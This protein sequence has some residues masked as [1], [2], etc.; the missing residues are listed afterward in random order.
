VTPFRDLLFNEAID[1]EYPPVDL[2]VLGGRKT[3]SELLATLDPILYSARRDEWLTSQLDAA[4][5]GDVLPPPHVGK[6]RERFDHLAR[7]VA[8]QRVVPFVGA[9]VSA[10][11]GF[12]TWSGYLFKLASEFAFPKKTLTELLARDS[13]EEAATRLLKQIGEKSFGESFD[14]SFDKKNG[15][16]AG[17]LVN[18][19]ATIFAGPVITT[20]Y[21]Q[22]LERSAV[23]SF[24]QTFWGRHPGDF[25][26]ACREGHRVLLKIH[27]DLYQPASRVLTKDEYDAPTAPSTSQGSYPRH[28]GP[29]SCVTRFCSW[30][31]VWPRIARWTCF[32]S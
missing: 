24:V 3:A 30:V 25:Q 19:V 14:R 2:P 26:R 8:R 11:S 20:N 21:D 23:P 1:E 22:L 12:P 32:T 7:L 15:G 29:F 18:L 17:E 28:S 9:G 27:G 5:G 16:G 13:F 31:R 6:N 10:A 4:L